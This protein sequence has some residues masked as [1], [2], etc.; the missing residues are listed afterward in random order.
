MIFVNWKII[1]R[2]EVKIFKEFPNIDSEWT[3][4]LDRDGTINQLLPNRYV[5]TVDEFKFIPGAKKA[6]NVFSQWFKYVIIV[7]NQQGI[8]KQLMTHENLSEVHK[9]MVTEISESG[10][11][12]D[13]IYY[14]PHLDAFNP[15]CRKPNIGMAYQALENF[16]DIDFRKSIIVGDSACDIEFGNR[17]KMY[18]IW[19]QN[20]YKKEEVNPNMIV[21]SLDELAM[22]LT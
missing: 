18:S 21:H 12:I 3:L 16:P 8:G 20:S 22:Y 11:R 14:C 17:L 19:I 7:T 2:Y 10:G 5:K 13:E 6:I 4:F 1:F 15:S 9:F